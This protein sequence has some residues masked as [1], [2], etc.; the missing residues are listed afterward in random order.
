[1][2]QEEFKKYLQSLPPSERKQALKD[3]FR[4]PGALIE[5][6]KKAQKDATNIDVRTPQ[7]RLDEQA[8]R[9][10]QGAGIVPKNNFLG[11]VLL[12]LLFAFG[13][14]YLLVKAKRK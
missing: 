11:R 8:A 12:A 13:G 1:M 7:Q 5:K 2:N 10:E 14:V 4:N 9:N 3:Y 6:Q